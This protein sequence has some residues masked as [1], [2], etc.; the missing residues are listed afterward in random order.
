MFS[1]ILMTKMKNI[2]LLIHQTSFKIVI[3]KF[4]LSAP[5]DVLTSRDDVQIPS[6]RVV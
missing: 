3:K 6:E 1:V 5:F 2:N 4:N